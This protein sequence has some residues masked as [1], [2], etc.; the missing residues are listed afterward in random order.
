MQ[1]GQPVPQEFIETFTETFNLVDED[2]DGYISKSEAILLFRGLGQALSE[3]AVE[4]LQ[5]KMPE[6]ID[7]QEFLRMFPQV[8]ADSCSEADIVKAFRV[9][10]LSNSGVLPVAKFRELLNTV[11]IPMKP[12]EVCLLHP[13]PL[14]PFIL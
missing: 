7:F 5:Q 2:R 9:F 13:I 3:S 6:N 1:A 10:D 8:Y 12:E 14:A 4:A 11:A